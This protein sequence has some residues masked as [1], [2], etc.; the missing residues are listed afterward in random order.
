LSDSKSV[1]FR[2]DE[3]VVNFWE[4]KRAIVKEPE[5]IEVGKKYRLKSTD[6]KEGYLI[7][8]T[9]RL[10]FVD[11]ESAVNQ[12]SEVSLLNLAELFRRKTPTEIESP[13]DGYTFVYRLRDIRRKKEFNKFKE[14][15]LNNVQAYREANGIVPQVAP[16]NEDVQDH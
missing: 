13:S 11:N 2:I 8:T 9:Q 1:T 12:V 5:K 7:L 6:W 16:D 14:Q 3:K 10:L 4:G 15:I